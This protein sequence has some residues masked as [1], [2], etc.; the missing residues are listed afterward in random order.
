MFLSHSCDDLASIVMSNTVADYAKKQSKAKD[1]PRII[2]VRKRM[3]QS[4]L[5]RTAS[6][7]ILGAEHVFHRFLLPG[8]WVLS[9]YRSFSCIGLFIRDYHFIYLYISDDYR[10]IEVKSKVS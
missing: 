7:E 5:N 6:H 3:L 8:S 10:I 9:F 1:D 4:F 2:E